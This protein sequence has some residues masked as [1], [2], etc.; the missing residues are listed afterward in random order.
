VSHII[1]VFVLQTPPWEFDWPI[2][3]YRASYHVATI[4]VSPPII[5][6]LMNVTEGILIHLKWLSSAESKRKANCS[7]LLQASSFKLQVTYV[8]AVSE[9]ET[10]YHFCLSRRKPTRR[11]IGHNFHVIQ[12]SACEIALRNFDQS[13]L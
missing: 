13:Q 11:C 5:A 9:S 12:A 3:L 6:I 8:Y 4:S 7:S 2:W 10:W 1:A